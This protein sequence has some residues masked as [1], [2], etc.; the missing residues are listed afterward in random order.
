VATKKEDAGHIYLGYMRKI[1][2]AK[3]LH[4]LIWAIKWALVVFSAGAIVVF[5][6][7]CVPGMQKM[8]ESLNKNAEG[9]EFP[10]A[11]GQTDLAQELKHR[12]AWTALPNGS[13]KGYWTNGFIDR[14][15]LYRI[16]MTEEVF[17]R[18]K[19]AIRTTPARG[20]RA[21]GWNDDDTTKHP[22]SDLP[23]PWKPGH[24]RIP[25]WWKKMP[26]IFGVSHSTGMASVHSNFLR[27]RRLRQPKAT[28]VPRAKPPEHRRVLLQI[29][30]STSVSA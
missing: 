19:T 26:G 2:A 28:E 22:L 12:F 18:M 4:D 3:H 1:S 11:D 21:G 27:M 30:P 9:A 13:V 16:Q 25:K 23:S 17:E 6:G 14:N 5:L 29:L 15:K 24:P 20:S 7:F 10:L 8:Q